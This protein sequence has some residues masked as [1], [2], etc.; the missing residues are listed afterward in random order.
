[1]QLIKIIMRFGKASATFLTRIILEMFSCTAQAFW[2]VNWSIMCYVEA[3]TYS[4][5]LQP[6]EKI[7]HHNENN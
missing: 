7:E 5:P 3:Q 2:L 6:F 1:M 4:V